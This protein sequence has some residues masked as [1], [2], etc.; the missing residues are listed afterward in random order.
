MRER[1][2]EHR[3]GRGR[4]RRRHRIQSRL[5]ALSCQHRAR[6]GAWTHKLWDHDLSQSW[7]LN[8]L[9]HPGAPDFWNFYFLIFFFFL[10][11]IYFWERE[12][13]KAKA[14]EGQRE[15]ERDRHRIQWQAPGSELP[16][17]TEPNT[18]LEPM[19]RKIMTWAEVGRLTNWATQM[20]LEL[21]LI[22]KFKKF[23]L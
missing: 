15:R 8:R 5:Q 16:V 9:T 12:R 2:T 23:W 19:N 17:S 10:H 13:E 11:F 20:P 6:H 14:R 4:E 7:T 18:G 3:Q 22:D 1:G 21:F